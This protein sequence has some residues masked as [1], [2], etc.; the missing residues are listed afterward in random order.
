MDAFAR[1]VLGEVEQ[2]I[3]WNKTKL[4]VLKRDWRNMV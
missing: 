1:L 2:R 4:A 3:L